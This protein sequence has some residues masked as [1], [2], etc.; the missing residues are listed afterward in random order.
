ML[1]TL[2]HILNTNNDSLIYQ[3]EQECSSTVDMLFNKIGMYS[4]NILSTIDEAESAL[5][6]AVLDKILQNIHQ[7]KG[8]ARSVATHFVE[9]IS[10]KSGV[11]VYSILN[12]VQCT[13]FAGQP[14]YP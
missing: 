14:V 13:Y 11:S 10:R 12:E 4:P 5:Y 9:L 3:V 1:D 8:S 2:F 7:N 6:H